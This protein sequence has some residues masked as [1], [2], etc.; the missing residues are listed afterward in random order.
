MRGGGNHGGDTHQRPIAVFFCPPTKQKKRKNPAT[1]PIDDIGTTDD[2]VMCRD[3][4]HT[5]RSR[6]LA[7]DAVQRHERLRLRYQL[8]VSSLS[9]SLGAG[10]LLVQIAVCHRDMT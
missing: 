4:H 5:K 3:T 8:A 1:L 9:A 2:S 10:T 6:L 7:P